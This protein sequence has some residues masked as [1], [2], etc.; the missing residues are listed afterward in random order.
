MIEKKAG[1]IVNMASMAGYIGTPSYSVY[2][3]TKF[4]VRGFTEALRRE[5]GV[6]GILV[7]GVYPGGVANEFIQHSGIVR[8]TGIR[9][10]NFL[11]LTSEE[12]SKAVL[13]VVVKRKRDLVI[14][15]PMHVVIW[16]N[17]FFPRLMDWVINLRFTRRERID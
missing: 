14:P 11:R 17:I 12:V 9:T 15:W 13:R 1:H 6:Y 16:L 7:S 4:G 3:A 2:A 10:P 8:K 5:V